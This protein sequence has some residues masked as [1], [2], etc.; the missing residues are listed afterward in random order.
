MWNLFSRPAQAS[1]RSRLFKPALEVLEDRC[2]PS[3]IP[4]IPPI[5]QNAPQMIQQNAALLG[6]AAQ[7]TM[8][9]FGYTI[10]ADVMHQLSF[11]NQVSQS[12][13]KLVKDATSGASPRQIVA[14]ASQLASTAQNALASINGISVA[15]Q[16]AAANVLTQLTPIQQF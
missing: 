6:P 10:Q 1:E 3:G 7:Q 11:I 8:A 9:Q 14:D 15:E 12:V 16:T 2:L 4:P 13:Q 5:S